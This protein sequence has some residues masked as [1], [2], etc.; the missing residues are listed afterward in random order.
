MAIFY[1]MVEKTIEVFMEDFSIVGESF[2]N[3]LEN[4]RV[5]LVK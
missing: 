5:M 1:D 2:D 3:C 4:L